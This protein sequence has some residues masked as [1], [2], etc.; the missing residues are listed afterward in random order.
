MYSDPKQ[1]NDERYCP[2]CGFERG[3]DDCTCGG[4]MHI[5][6]GYES[7]MDYLIFELQKFPKRKGGN[8]NEKL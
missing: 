5:L 8:S 6:S 7:R 4:L 2:L 1:E 3:T